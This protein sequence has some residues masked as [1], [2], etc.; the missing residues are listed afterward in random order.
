MAETT[1]NTGGTGRLRLVATEGTKQPENNRSAINWAF[2]LE[3]RTSSPTTWM[4]GG[5]S[6]SVDVGGDGNDWSGTFGFDWR[7]GGLQTKLIASGSEWRTHNPDGSGSVTVYAHMGD[8][9]TVGAGGPT[10]IQLSLS[11]STLKV[12]PPAPTNLEA[13]V[14]SDTQIRLD[15]TQPSGASN[16]APSEHVIQRRKNQPDGTGDNDGWDS[17]TVISPNTTATVSASPNEKWEYR[18]WARNSAGQRV[19]N[20]SEPVYTTPGAPTDAE[21]VKNASLDIIVSWTPHVDYTEHSHEVWHGV[22]SGGVPTWD[23]TPLAV[24]ASGTSTYTHEDPDAGDI[25]IYRVRAVAGSL[26]SGYSTTL[27]VQLL[28]APNKPTIPTMPSY[29]D[30]A[31]DFVFSWVHNPQDTTPQSAYELAHSTN[32]GSSWTSTNK[33][34][35]TVSS[36]TIPAGTFSA[37]DVV[38]WRVRT[39]GEATTGGSDGTGASP[40]SDIKTVTFKTRP[41][42][43][44]TSPVDSSTVHDATLRVNL[45]FSQA[46]SA[47]FVS[48]TLELVHSSVVIETKSTTLLIGTTLA[49]PVENGETYT[50]RARVRDSNGIWSSWDSNTFD[51][52]Y[53]SP[54]TPNINLTYLEDN[55]FA[56]IDVSIP[57]PGAQ[58]DEVETITITR[59]IDGGPEEIILENFPVQAN[60]SWIDTTPTIHGTNTY[61]IT[62]ASAL[63]AQKTVTES[64]V[65]NECRRAFLSKGQGFSV[66]GVFGAN[67]SVSESLSVA[68]NTVEAAG[69]TKPIGLYGIETNVQ[70][71][72]S[73]FVFERESYSTIPE[74]RA[75]LLM[76]G[77]SCYRDASGRRVFGS[78]KGSVKYTKATRGEL[79]FTLTETS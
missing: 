73:S 49:T 75:L 11:L 56:Q 21:A 18:V 48:A 38:Q 46:E 24:V 76:P 70:L 60:N 25:H 7:P 9:G 59:S 15:W 53:L 23:G 51:V 1:K 50:I 63:G 3:E 2:Y 12:L 27:A 28:T 67:L 34:T 10:N 65:T 43:S 77:K 17:G 20:I 16:G 45:S 26:N 33:V 54:V 68:S 57:E 62:V 42:V 47:S 40:W 74:L 35:S 52:E 32:G 66:V 37:D 22:V 41:T 58:E 69:R 5:I 71:K 8:T 78:V 30:K 29:A 64:L 4:G 19:S 79:S 44:I 36:R 6:A 55:G 39:W 72:V 14:I 61:R 31:A 13:T